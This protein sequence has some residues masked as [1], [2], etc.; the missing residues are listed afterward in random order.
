VADLLLTLIAHFSEVVWFRCYKQIFVK[1]GVYQR[2]VGH[3]KHTFHLEGD[4]AH[5]PVLVSENYSDYRFMWY[6]NIGSMFCRFTT[7]QACEDG[8]TDRI[9][10]PRTALA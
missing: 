8:M 9:T 10:I 5:Q 1:V 7:K 3:F 2:W 6:H 4:I